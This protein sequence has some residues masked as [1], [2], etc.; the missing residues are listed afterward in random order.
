[1]TTEYAEHILGLEKFITQDGGILRTVRL[2]L[3]TPL[4]I[5]WKLKVPT[6]MELDL[7]V[8][9]QE[10][11]KKALKIGLHHQ[12]DTAQH[13]LLRVDYHSRH[14]NPVDL[15]DAVP[16]RFHPYAG[17]FLDQWPGH[18]HY[19]VDGFPTLAWAIPLEADS[20]P[21]KD[22]QGM[23]HVRNAVLAFCKRL[24]IA[25]QVTIENTQLRVL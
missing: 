24:N 13:G 15:T 2:S 1:M 9:I 17:I 11:P 14:R 7:R 6:E 8:E 12:D 5:R 10:S 18:I 19:V 20:F 21:V 3:D 22:I 16:Q 25:T 4:N 23:D